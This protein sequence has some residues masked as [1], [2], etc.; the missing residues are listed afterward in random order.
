[1]QNLVFCNSEVSGYGNKLE[2]QIKAA[3]WFKKQNK[4]PT[5]NIWKS[6]T[7]GYYNF[8][9][10]K[11]ITLI[12]KQYHLWKKLLSCIYVSVKI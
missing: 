1:M 3:L 6:G 9:C 5:Q 11:N 12:Y 10:L 7:I 8:F 4:K 2:D